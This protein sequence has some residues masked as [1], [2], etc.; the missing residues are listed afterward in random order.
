M[1]ETEKIKQLNNQPRI[2]AID[3]QEV[4]IVE[5]ASKEEFIKMLANMGGR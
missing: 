4:T 3:V 5:L 2:R 1:R